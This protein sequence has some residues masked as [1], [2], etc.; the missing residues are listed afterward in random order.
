MLMMSR[1]ILKPTGKIASLVGN[2]PP[3]PNIIVCPIEN[4]H[5]SRRYFEQQSNR[6]IISVPP[7][8]GIFG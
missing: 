5:L 2:L 4:V 8:F 1:T 6:S 7:V 3:E